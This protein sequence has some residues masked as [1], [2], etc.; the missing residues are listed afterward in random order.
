MTINEKVGQNIRKYRLAHN[1]TL[2]DLSALVHKS[3][4]TLS[5]YEKGT[6]PITVD[7]V[8]EFAEVFQ[9]PPAHLL[10]TAQDARA[11]ITQKDILFRYYMYSYDGKR[12]RILK[13]IIE[14]FSTSDPEISSIQLFYDVEHIENFEKCAVIYAGESTK[15]GPWKNYHLKNKAHLHEEIWM[16]TLDTFSQQ[17]RKSGILSGVSQLTMA[18]TSRK[19]LTS[20]E[21]LKDSEIMNELTISKDDIQLIKKYNSFNINS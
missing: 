17:N 21:I 12:K 16:C 10:S 7:T 11:E 20:P 4:S 1:Y 13:S 15:F 9:L 8:E 14:E 3:C 6:I 2:K 18:P 19:I 5:K